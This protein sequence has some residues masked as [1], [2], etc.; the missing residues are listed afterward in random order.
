M[1]SVP[2]GSHLGP[3]S[4]RVRDIANKEGQVNLRNRRSARRN[5]LLSGHS[6]ILLPYVVQAGPVSSSTASRHLN[7]WGILGMG[8]PRTQK[9]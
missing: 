5:P 6:A 1:E 3:S 8:S 9:A 7:H 4:Q 2:D